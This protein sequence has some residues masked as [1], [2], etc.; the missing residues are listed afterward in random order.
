MFQP[1]RPH[2]ARRAPGPGRRPRAAG[3]QPTRPHGARL[4]GRGYG[5]PSRQ[6]STH[7]PAR[8]AT[9]LFSDIRT[10]EKGF[11]P[12]RPHGARHTRYA[13]HD[14]QAVFQ[15]TRPHG[16]RLPDGATVRRVG[17][18]Q[19]TRPHG[20]RPVLG[21]GLGVE[22]LVSTHAPARGA[23][24]AARCP[25]TQRSRFNP[26]ART[27][28]DQSDEPPAGVFKEFQPT[29]PYGA[30]PVKVR[31]QKESGQFQPTRPYGARPWCRDRSR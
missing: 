8:G 18:F 31:R 15:P 1:T 5:A 27:G 4:P 30:R 7:A 3:F 28:R 20:A 17:K 11:Q 10:P 13:H 12:T 16:A 23:T 24:R 9:L 25:A 26:R 6:V 19:P 14:A 22:D 2:G 29:R 21:G